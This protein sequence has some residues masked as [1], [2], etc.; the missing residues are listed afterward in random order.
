MF[1]LAAR[2]VIPDQVCTLEFTNCADDFQIGGWTKFCTKEEP[3][4]VLT[5]IEDVTADMKYPTY[6][7]YDRSCHLL[8]TIVGDESLHHWLDRTR[9]IVDAFHF[10]RFAVSFLPN[11][12]MVLTD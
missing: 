2:Y 3:E 7:A 12:G 11:H 9:F 8:T 6:L 10:R 4:E 5:F 1:T